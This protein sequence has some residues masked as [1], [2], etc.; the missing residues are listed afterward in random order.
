M[1]VLIGLILA[2][3]L[4]ALFSDRATRACRWREYRGPEETRWRCIHCGA[5]TTGARP[6]T[7]LRSD[8]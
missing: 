8:R 4:I 6:R 2:L 7:C 3:V 1:L 5:E